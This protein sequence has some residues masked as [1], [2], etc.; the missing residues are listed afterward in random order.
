MSNSTMY[1]TFQEHELHLSPALRG[2]LTALPYICV[3]ICCP[4][5]VAI[6][7]YFFKSCQEDNDNPNQ[8]RIVPWNRQNYPP[9]KFNMPS[10]LL[11]NPQ[12]FPDPANHGFA[13]QNMLNSQGY[14]NQMMSNGPPSYSTS[15]AI[16]TPVAPVYNNGPI[17]TGYDNHNVNVASY[18]SYGNS[19][20]QGSGIAMGA[21]VS[22]PMQN[23]GYS[24]PSQN[25]SVVN[26]NYASASH[27][28]NNPY[29][30]GYT[31]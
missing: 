30:T 20:Q 25:V 10:N 13:A 8:Q 5:V 9:P 11:Y 18:N 7:F 28:D 12:G 15:S 4:F 19:S 16:A 31:V 24:Y 3:V 22:Q 21:I 29:G 2:F 23:N 26:Q 27:S 14:S 17:K 1:P 6:K